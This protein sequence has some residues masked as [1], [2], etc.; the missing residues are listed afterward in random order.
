MKQ[1]IH[2]VAGADSRGS[3]GVR[4][5]RLTIWVVTTPRATLPCADFR[6]GHGPR[7]LVRTI[8]AVVGQLRLLELLE[9]APTK[10][11]G[12]LSPGTPVAE[13]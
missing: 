13:R 7:A 5:K 11:L 6:A 8:S 3:T 10:G 4:T 2:G 9:L 1:S 12:S